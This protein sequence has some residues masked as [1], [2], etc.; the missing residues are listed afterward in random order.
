MK[1]PNLFRKPTASERA[2]EELRI[3]RLQRLEA[4][5]CAEHWTHT[6]AML[7]ERIAR[8][9]YAADEGLLQALGEKPPRPRKLATKPRAVA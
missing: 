1:L 7:D 8:L 6:A 9:E 2:A 5:A 4:Q 3:A